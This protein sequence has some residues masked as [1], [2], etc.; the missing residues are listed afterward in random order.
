MK[1]EGNEKNGMKQKCMQKY[2]QKL[3][4]LIHEKNSATRNCAKTYSNVI[5]L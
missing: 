1:Y 2:M 5:K 3:R 4:L